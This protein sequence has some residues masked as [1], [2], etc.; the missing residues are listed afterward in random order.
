MREQCKL[1]KKHGN[2]RHKQ[3][4]VSQTAKII[5]I[6]IAKH[7]CDVTI[8]ITMEILTTHLKMNFNVL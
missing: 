6:L 8:Q 3:G 2:T 7:K 4:S 5:L 1:Q